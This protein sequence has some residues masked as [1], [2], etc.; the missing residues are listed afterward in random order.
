MQGVKVDKTLSL[1]YHFSHSIHYL[2]SSHG[3]LLF[4]FWSFA[5]YWHLWHLGHSTRY[6]CEHAFGYLDPECV[7][8]FLTH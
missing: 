5:A 2:S 1:E 3:Q 8:K 4:V 7:D 6:I